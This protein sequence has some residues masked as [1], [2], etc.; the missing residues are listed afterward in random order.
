MV[1]NVN[2]HGDAVM[3]VRNCHFMVELLGY[4]DRE[5][6]GWEGRRRDPNGGDCIFL[7]SGILALQR[8]AMIDLSVSY[9]PV[10][11]QNIP[12]KS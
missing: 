8:K 3:Q 1:P 10:K 4:M 9:F 11:P 5:M 12:G 6:L 2:L 7:L